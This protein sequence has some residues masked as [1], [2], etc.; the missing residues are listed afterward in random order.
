[1]EILAVVVLGVSK[2]V[3]FTLTER[4]PK[5][6]T[7]NRPEDESESALTHVGTQWMLCDGKV[8]RLPV[9]TKRCAFSTNREF[10]LSKWM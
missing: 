7:D 1:M 3:S 10:Q 2:L 6:E 5:T 9:L 8:I 4:K